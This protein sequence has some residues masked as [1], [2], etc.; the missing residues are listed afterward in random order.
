ML[1]PTRDLA[2]QVF[3]VFQ[4]LC[5][6]LGLHVALATG[7]QSFVEEQQRIVGLLTPEQMCVSCLSVRSVIKIG[8]GK[9]VYDWCI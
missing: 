3:T 8:V 4:S 5:A 9:E 6:P 1:L 7:Q 2:R